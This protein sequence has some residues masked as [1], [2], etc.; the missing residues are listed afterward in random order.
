MKTRFFPQLL[1]SAASITVGLIAA[2]APA[3]AFNFTSNLAPGSSNPEGDILLQSV[4]YGGQTISDLTLINQAVIL[5]NTAITA[6][7]GTTSNPEDTSKSNDNSGAA[8][9]DKGDNASLPTG[10]SSVSG[11]NNPTGTEVAAFLGNRNLNNIIDTEDS[12]SFKMNLTFAQA[13]SN[14]FLWERGMNSKLAVQALDATGNLI[15][16][17]LTLDS[18]TFQYAGYSIDTMEIDG[19]QRVGSIGISLADLGVTGAISSLQVSAN[20]SFSGPDFKIMGASSPSAT[21]PEPTTM[22]GSA[23][24]AGGLML[25]RRR[26]KAASKA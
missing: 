14:I 1:L 11:I 10:I 2:N 9:T 16:N 25:R 19:A 24:A 13:V 22:I 8:S 21:V 7:A 12:G 17:L 26:Q 3:Q 18:S 6:A 23:L 5:S 15:G 4:T 20:S